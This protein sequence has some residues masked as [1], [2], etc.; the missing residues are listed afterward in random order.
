MVTTLPTDPFL[1]TLP[2]LRAFAEVADPA[3]YR[4]LP[5]GWW[6]GI[7]DVVRSTGAIAAGRYK[8]VNMAGAAA[9]AAVGN[10]LGQAAFPFA[11][12]GDGASFAVPPGWIGPAREALAATAT[13]VAEEFDLELRVAIV[14]IE[15]IRAAGFDVALARFAASP[16]LHYTM[17]S[18]GG[19][20]WAEGRMKGGDFA[21]APAPPGTRPDLTGLSCR[22]DE[23]PSRRGTIL[24]VIVRPADGRGDAAFATLVADILAL[25]EGSPDMARPISGSGPPIAWPPAGLDL[26]ARLSRPVGASALWHRMKVAVRSAFTVL[27]FRFRLPIGRFD[28]DRYLAELVANTDWR[29]Y[30]DG[31]RLTLDL[32][33]ALADAIEARLA[34][35]EREGVARS[36]T[37]RQA[38]SLL[39]CITPS[40]HRSDHIHFVDGADGG[41]AAAAASLKG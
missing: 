28:P 21:L 18:G 29:K 10:A 6:I 15:A 41:Y 1:D 13:L 7:A 23:A 5:A 2:V 34:R 30:D 24:S 35:A 38:A 14:P 12:G 25:A 16:D 27:V 11:F 9:I 31:L 26:E 20:A 8:A 39:T 19:L 37:H 17:F 4:P 3:A 36:G 32:D 22:F 40:V 33:P